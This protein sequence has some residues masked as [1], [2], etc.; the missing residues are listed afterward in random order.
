M[1][2]LEKEKKVVL[3]VVV[4]TKRLMTEYKQMYVDERKRF[5]LVAM[6]SLRQNVLTSIM[7]EK[8]LCTMN[9]LKKFSRKNL[10][11]RERK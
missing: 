1:R 8:Q 3:I 9:N 10:P 2:D 7:E 4:R 5:R 6:L 11:I